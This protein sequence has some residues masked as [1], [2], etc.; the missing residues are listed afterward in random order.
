MA[1]D[2][3]LRFLIPCLLNHS[4]KK[5]RREI[6]E[7]FGKGE[8][9]AIVANQVLDEG[10]DMPKAKVAVVV[11]GKASGRQ[12]IQRLGRVLRRSGN[13]KAVLYEVICEDTKE[14]ERSRKRRRS[15][16]YQGT[17]HRRI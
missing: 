3:S 12:A 11:G 8:Y 17:R 10:V 15:D 9:P 5:E 7:G 4:G 6:L 16:A 2:V 14:E 1:R 13:E